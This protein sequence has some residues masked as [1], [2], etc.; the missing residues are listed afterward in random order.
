M[1]QYK[2]YLIDL[3]GTMYKG[4]QSIPGAAEFIQYLN[5][6]DIPHLFVTNNSTKAPEDVVEKLASVDVVAQPEEVITSAMATA[7]YISENHPGASIYMIGDNGLKTALT[8]KGLT[9]KDDTEVDF[10]V[11]GLDESVDYEKLSKATLA[12]QHGATFI[13]T[14]PDPTIPKEQGFLPG[15][16]SITSVI[17][18]SVNQNPTFIGKPEKP[19]MQKALDVLQLDQKDVAMIGDLYDTDIMS[20]INL[21]VDTIHVQTGVTSKEE[22][23]SKAQPPTYSVENLNEL[24]QLLNE[25]E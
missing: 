6:Q 8:D 19:I 10:V 9:V 16:G 15:N 13:S 14:N 12:V 25:R 2:G 5:D 18:V 24:R 7:D 3:D 21:G 22:A 1:K 4:S 20:G 23:M 11:V 17:T